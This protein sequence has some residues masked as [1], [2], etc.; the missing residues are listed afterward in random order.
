MIGT[1]W[2]FTPDPG[3]KSYVADADYLHYGF[4]LMKTTDADGAITYD[5]VQT[6]A[7][8]SILVSGDVTAVA[9]TAE[10]NGGATGV[11][12]KNVYNPDR[13][14]ES[15][16]SGF[17]TANVN[18]MAYFGGP[19]ISED[20]EDSVTGTIDKFVLQHGED[21]MWSVVLDGDIIPDAA[22][23]SGTADGGGGDP[24]SFNATFHGPTPLTES[25]EDDAAFTVAPGL[26]GWRIQ[27]Q[28][29]RRHC[30]RRLRGAQ[31]VEQVSRAGFLR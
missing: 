8:S 7:G 14:I 13:T 6:F 25:M 3:A 17:F 15:A 16:T 27:R 22:T 10:Y 1:G 5:E 21:N 28:L 24:G 19:S 23:A 29:Q 2:I 9:G 12:V 31:V 18:L 4:W 11:Y 20:L 30:G 26:R